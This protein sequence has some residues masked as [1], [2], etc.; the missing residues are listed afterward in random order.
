MELTAEQYAILQSTG[1]IKI[2]A[3]AGS[4]KTTT[5]IEYAASRPAHS[6]ILYLAFN[7]SVRLEA[8]K[9]FA[10]KG[11]HNVK[12][13]TAH[14][15]AYKH[16]VFKNGYRV[17]S[18]AYKTNEIAELLNLK[19]NGEK[20]AEYIIANHINKFVSY[21]C[22]S[23][24]QRVQELNYLETIADSKAKAF[25]S[26]FYDYIAYQTRLLLSR[27]DKGEIEITHD[28]YL[29]KFQLSNPALHYDYILFDEA[30]D[31]SA[32]M[33]D[34][35]LKQ[36]A[37][38]VI[39]G[40]THQQ[41]Y[42]WRHAVNSLEKADFKTYHLSISF[43]FSQDIANLA[44]KVLEYKKHL[45]E[46]PQ[47]GITGKGA[48]KEQK[49][50][51]VIARTNLGLLLKAIEYVTEKRKVKH[52]YFEGNINS[53]TYA[54]EGASLYDVLN[55]YNGKYNLIK[56]KLMA[57][58][59]NIDELESYIEKTE[60]VQ[61]GMMVEIVKAYG[62]EIPAIIEAIKE[63]HVEGDDKENAEMI[64]STVHR[65]KGME[66]DAIQLVNDFITEEKLEQLLK[67]KGAMTDT[68][69]LNEEI[70][71][72]YVA[73]TRTRNAIYIPETLM[74]GNF[75]ASSQI[76]LM[77]T[78]AK[79]EKEKTAAPHSVKMQVVKGTNGFLKGNTYPAEKVRAP[80]KDAYLPWTKDLDEEL[81]TMYSEG[82]NMRDLAKHFGRTKGAIASRIKKLGI[83]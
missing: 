38:K 39:V 4:G 68:A 74:P 48:G 71:L 18:Q 20:H 81:I 62:N 78:P 42:S 51:A 57:A 50:K 28:F 43:R 58:M 76:H 69:K 14:S 29:K 25:V 2:N 15:L 32:A 44:M 45:N 52:I 53:Y 7:K 8:A 80:Y 3:V 70:N 77:R 56:D 61:L 75:P 33:L 17:R 73:V 67:D 11:L 40:D 30:Q 24:K 63:K 9:K 66:Y 55:L 5:I 37:T 83:E 34:I 47:T 6:K 12:V 21:Y 23:D 46:K 64:F 16:V 59:K 26:A 19:G 13:E 65:C 49:T 35:F 1:N 82:L 60:D 36:E 41:I 79:Q 54:D 10:D 22:N 72:L 27:M 31:A